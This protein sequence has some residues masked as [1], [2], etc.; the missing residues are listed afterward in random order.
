MTDKVTPRPWA[1]G[2]DDKA[3]DVC[4]PDGGQILR[5]KNP[6]KTEIAN[7]RHIVKC[8]NNHERLVEAL[9]QCAVEL[10]E[11]VTARYKGTL[12]YPSQRR[13]YEADMS[14]VRDARALLNELEK[15]Q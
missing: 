4:G 13:K 8:V 11:E 10:E 12:D 7:A 14:T 3:V 9:R 6:G 1:S 5:F 15:D 2:C